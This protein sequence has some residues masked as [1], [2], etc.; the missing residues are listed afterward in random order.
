MRKEPIILAFSEKIDTVKF[1]KKNYLYSITLP[2]F[3][4]IIAGCDNGSDKNS[5]EAEIHSEQTKT[6]EDF[7]PWEKDGNGVLLSSKWIPGKSYLFRQI[8][9]TEMDLPLAGADGSST[10]MSIDLRVDVDEVDNNSNKVIK[11]GFDK[12]KMSM[13]MAGQDMVYDSQDPENQSPLLKTALSNLNDQIYEAKFDENNKILSLE[14]AGDEV[15]S[16]IGMGAMGKE[17]I[18]NMIQ[19]LKD[20][21]FPESV[22]QPNARWQNKQ[23]FKMQQIGEMNMTIDY[24]YN[25]PVDSSG[26]KLAEIDFEGKAE[27]SGEGLVSFKDSKMT[28]T[29][30]FD[31]K[32]GML[33]KSETKMEM[34]MSIGG[35][36]GAEMDTTMISKYNLISV[37]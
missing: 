16:G 27:T 29:L 20:F 22:V 30:L 10:E 17:E 32:L 25:G 21:G 11:I 19:Q 35:A 12:V 2:L 9:D 33:I 36:A 23:N 15:G 5:L 1:M 18:E 28:G 24:T 31:P 37:E 4:L 14:G 8:T 26:K 6:Q 13:Q 3:C 34:T 7:D